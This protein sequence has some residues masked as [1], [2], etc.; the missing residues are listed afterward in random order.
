[1]RFP[2][3]LAASLLALALSGAAPA[4]ARVLG[5]GAEQAQALDEARRW[6]GRWCPITGC[7]TPPASAASLGGFAAAALGALLL[8]RRRAP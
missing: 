2:S 3:L 5:D 4:N 7:A 6:Q 1:M 8:A